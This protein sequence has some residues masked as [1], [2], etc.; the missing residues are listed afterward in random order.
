MSEI[1]DFEFIVTE[2]SEI[3]LIKENRPSTIIMLKGIKSYPFSKSPMTLS[4]LIIT[5]Q[6]KDGE[7]SILV[8]SG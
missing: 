4:R 6:V 8:L 3:N 1:V 7:D 2:S 5:R